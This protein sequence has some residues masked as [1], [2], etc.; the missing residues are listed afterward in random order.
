M[1]H[2]SSYNVV[3]RI[4]ALAA[5]IP[6]MYLRAVN[7][8]E[9]VVVLM[10]FLFYCGGYLLIAVAP[11]NWTD[12]Q[13]GYAIGYSLSMEVALGIVLIAQIPFSTLSSK[14]LW[15]SRAALCAN[16]GLFVIAMGAWIWHRKRVNHISVLGFLFTG[17]IY[18]CCGFPR[19]D[20]HRGI[21][22]SISMPGVS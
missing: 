11:A 8:S 10:T 14:D 2:N 3:L 9:A 12:F 15:Y 18:P 19:G 13:I 22:V 5:G 16:I 20:A 1:S 21:A 7:G 17:I 4:A 6:V